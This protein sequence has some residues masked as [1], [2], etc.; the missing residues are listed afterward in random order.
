M[1]HHKKIEKE[2]KKNGIN[3]KGIS[4]TWPGNCFGCSP[5]NQ[6]GLHLKIKLIDK[7]AVSYTILSEDFCG[8][9]KIAHGGIIATLLDEIS[10]WTVLSNLSS[11]GVT[12]NAHIKF[13]KP[14]LLGMLIK[15]E[16][17][18]E[19]FEGKRVIVR[20][21]VQS[22]DGTIFAEGKTQFVIPGIKT[23]AQLVGE[24]ESTLKGMFEIFNNSI[25][26]NT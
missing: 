21:S 12:L 9:D 3:F 8:F 19:K 18:I 6:R 22:I 14:V 20:S 23:L 26:E 4:N 13:H 1:E 24:D 17:E 5:R 25:Q 15:V 2:L 16:G 11:Q 7:K 10:A